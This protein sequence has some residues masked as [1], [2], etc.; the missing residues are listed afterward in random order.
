MNYCHVS[1]ILTNALPECYEALKKMKACKGLH[2]ALVQ[3]ADCQG[4]FQIQFIF[5]NLQINN[6]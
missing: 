4:L 3:I 6:T 2:D 5:I 1:D